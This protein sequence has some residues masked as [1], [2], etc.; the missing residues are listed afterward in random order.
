MEGFVCSF[1]LDCEVAKR[2][3]RILSG[4]YGEGKFACQAAKPNRV[5]QQSVLT[6]TVSLLQAQKWGEQ[7]G[8]FEWMGSRILF[9]KNCLLFLFSTHGAEV[10]PLRIKSQRL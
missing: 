3:T 10:R 4:R 5:L 8:E 1:A 2:R 6:F 9:E 7:S